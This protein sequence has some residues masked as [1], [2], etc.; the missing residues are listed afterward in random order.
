LE[1]VIGGE[2]LIGIASPV[3]AGRFSESDKRVKIVSIS[4][5]KPGFFLAM[6]NIKDLRLL[7]G[8][9]IGVADLKDPNIGFLQSALSRV[10][11]RTPDYSVVSVG[12]PSLR[13]QSLVAG[14]VSGAILAEGAAFEAQKRDLAVTPLAEF[15]GNGI[16]TALV[17]RVDLLKTEARG[18]VRLLRALADAVAWMYRVENRLEVIA[19]I[20]KEYEIEEAAAAFIY[21]FLIEKN[22]IY[23][24]DFSAPEQLLMTTN[25]W[26]SWVKISLKPD[27]L[28]ASF[29]KEAGIK[30]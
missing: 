26:L 7:K 9:K 19:I 23:S 21:S 25:D 17:G 24:T 20:Q 10:G 12:P 1:L 3:E 13:L 4:R 15:L 11:L 5:A 14:A 6:R 28:E 16:E 22:K 18:V 30:K 27:I 29:F 8:T 2:F